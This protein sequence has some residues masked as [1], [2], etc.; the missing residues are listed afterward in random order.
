MH[1]HLVVAEL[2]MK[3]TVRGSV[4]EPFEVVGAEIVLFSVLT[5]VIVWAAADESRILTMVI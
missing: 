2:Y 1:L 5:Q 3:P 4:V